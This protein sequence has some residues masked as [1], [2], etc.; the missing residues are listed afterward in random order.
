MFLKYINK[1][2]DD[3]EWYWVFI[4]HNIVYQLIN[5]SINK[6]FNQG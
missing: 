2:D 5:N 1:N 3:E 4:F 6:P